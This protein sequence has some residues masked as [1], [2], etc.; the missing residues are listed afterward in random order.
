MRKREGEIIL[1]GSPISE[2]IGIGRFIFLDDLENVVAPEFSIP[3]TEVEHEISRYREA[4]DSS[5]EDLHNL[6]RFLAKEGSDEAV[7]IIDSHI[8]M[9]EDP[10][11]T[12]LMEKKIRQMMKNTESVFRSVMTDYEKEFAKVKDNFFKQRLT[13]VK[14]L[15][16]RILKNLSSGNEMSLKEL[17]KHSII[18]SRELGPSHA[19]E[20]SKGVIEGIVTEVGGATSHAALIARSKGIPYV[21][22]ID[23]AQLHIAPKGIVII[24][25][26]RGEVI[27]N[28]CEERLEKAKQ[29]KSSSEKGIKGKIGKANVETRDGEPFEIFANIDNIEDL[30]LVKQY[31]ATGVGLFRSEFLLLRK[32]LLSFSEE[33]QF[34]LFS[35]MMDVTQ[36]FPFTFRIFDIGGDKGKSYYHQSEPNPALGCRGIRF[37]LKHP[38]IF[39]AHLRALLRVSGQ[40]NLRILLPFIADMQELMKAKELIEETTSA[41]RQEGFVIPAKIP[42]GSMIEIPSAVMIADFLAKE[43]DFLSIGTNDLV[44]YTLAADRTTKE[45]H[46]YYKSHHPS[47]IRMIRHVVEQAAK[48]KKPICL[49]GEMASDPLM[50]PLLLSLGVR[51][52]SCSPRFIPIVKEMVSSISCKDVAF[53]KGEIN[54]CETSHQILSFLEDRYSDLVNKISK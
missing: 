29:K 50:L 47:I 23:I 44:Q 8:Q 10:M 26:T 13:D 28:P 9:L 30:H 46:E 31:G 18:V 54:R 35:E 40:G 5:R 6:Q 4:V 15:S 36:N 19:A 17:P 7:S 38:E 20:A 43:C 2:G 14:D 32:D 53:L 45:S 22:N 52:I 34:Y 51:S 41:L 3:F 1:K 39:L 27:I 49:C 11:M 48:E 24:D 25:G 33:E 37:L 21:A 42:L 12:T 16:K